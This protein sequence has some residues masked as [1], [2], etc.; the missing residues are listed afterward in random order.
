MLY[1]QKYLTNFQKLFL[2]KEENVAIA[3][4]NFKCTDISFTVVT[5]LQH[6][7]HPENKKKFNFS[8]YTVPAEIL[9]LQKYLTNF[10]KVF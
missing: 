2:A 5:R 1:L 6:F 4:E 9:Y 10:L 8:Q 3:A 7:Q